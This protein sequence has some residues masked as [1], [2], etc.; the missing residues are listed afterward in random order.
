MY[1]LEQVPQ[2]MVDDIGS[3]LQGGFNLINVCLRVRYGQKQV[4]ILSG[5]K[6]LQIV[7]NKWRM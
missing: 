2:G 6:I 7:S 3:L 1:A 5:A 4:W